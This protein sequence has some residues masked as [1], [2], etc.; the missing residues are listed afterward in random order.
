MSKQESVVLQCIW[1]SQEM[2]Q[3]WK[4]P[5]ITQQR[6]NACR[7]VSCCNHKG[8]TSSFKWVCVPFWKQPHVCL[9]FPRDQNSGL[10]IP[11]PLGRNPVRMALCLYWTSPNVCA[12]SLI[13][14]SLLLALQSIQP[15]SSGGGCWPGPRSSLGVPVALRR[16]TLEFLL[17]FPLGSLC[18]LHTGTGS[19]RV[20][21]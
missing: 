9:T 5:W 1:L 17:L 8:S 6:E 15:A 16:S 20:E 14:P 13:L 11:V 10:L 18:P 12:L 3:R 4:S 2:W 21:Y 19:H 7:K